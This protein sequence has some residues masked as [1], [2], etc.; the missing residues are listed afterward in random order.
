MS[1]NR[2]SFLKGTGA[3][4]GAACVGVPLPVI[5]AAAAAATEKTAGDKGVKYVNTTCVHC[6]NFCGQRIKMQDGVIRVVYPNPDIAEYYNHGICPKGGAGPFNTYNPYR[7]KAPLKRTNP[8]KGPHEDP[9][10]KEIS[11]DEA[12]TEIAGKLKT[13]KA[14]DPRKLVWHHGH[15]KY[16]IQDDFPKAFA[17]AFGTPNVVHRTTTC[18]ACPPC[19]RRAD[20]GLSRVPAGPGVLRPAAQPRR[21]LLRGRAMGAVAGPREHRCAGTRH[22]ARLSRA[23]SFQHRSQGRPVGTDSSRKGRGDAA[24]HGPGADRCRPSGRGVLGQCQ[25]RRRTGGKGRPHPQGQGREVPGLGY[26]KQQRQ[27]LC[28][29]GHPGSEGQLYRRWQASAHLF[30][31]AGRRGQAEVTPE[32]AENVTGIPAATIKALALEFGHKAQI[33]ATLVIDGKRLRYR[34]VAIHAFRGVAAKEFGVQTWRAGHL[35]MMLVGAH[36]AVGGLILHEPNHKPDLMDPSKCEYPPKRVDLKTS[37]YF[38]HATHN[39]C[40]QVAYTLLDPK[41]YG[42]DYM[43]EMQIF[44]ATNRVMSTSDAL[45]QFEGYAKTYNV[46]I[47]IVLTETAQMADIVLPDLTYLEAWQFAPTRWTPETR[48][49]AIRQPL[50]N[51]Y[52]LPLDAWGIIWELAKRVGVRDD[53]ANAIN[54]EFKLKKSTFQPG[55]DI[56][57]GMRWKF[58]G[59]RR[60]TNHST[61]RWNTRS[62]VSIS[63]PSSATWTVWSGSSWVQENRR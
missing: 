15:G 53:Y 47:D 52:N 51:V 25:Q 38:P 12:L 37:V 35:V 44:Y 55:R 28:A 7:I 58:C 6:V 56:P 62:W 22:E 43:P 20:V 8:K 33:G 26:R 1:L 13:I 63:M 39:V 57:H 45:K 34:P 60:R 31:S 3:L 54:A 50:T 40:Q 46:T 19:G 36:D 17:K 2:R 42:L 48:H 30:P 11:W 32:Y 23:A 21:E 5:A 27:T 9:G 59:M 41:A 10:W 24:S 29:R 4:A 18:E 49:T 16:L 61:T 14:D